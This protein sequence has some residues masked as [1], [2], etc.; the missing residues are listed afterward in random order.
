[1]SSS[2]RRGDDVSRTLAA[3]ARSTR[4]GVRSAHEVLTSLRRGGVPPEVAVQVVAEYQARGIVDDRACAQLWANH[5]A[6]QGYARALIRLKLSAKG[7]DAQVIDS[8][9]HR[10]GPPSDDEE[11]ARALV[12]SSLRRRERPSTRQ[13]SPPARHSGPL[14]VWRQVPRRTGSGAARRLARTLASRGFDAD[15]IERVLNEALDSP[16]QGG[17]AQDAC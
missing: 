5:W 14:G 12:A 6:R 16:A 1:M 3:V 8:A 11:R 10:L 17:I 15:L 7:L 4:A 2:K 9:V 13:R